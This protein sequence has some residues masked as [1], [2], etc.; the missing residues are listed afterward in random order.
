M[1]SYQYAVLNILGAIFSLYALLILGYW[2]FNFEINF[3]NKSQGFINVSGIILIVLAPVISVI[4]IK[5]GN[6]YRFG[7]IL[8]FAYLSLWLCVLIRFFT[9]LN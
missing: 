1:R 3:P 4:I 7:K 8:G 2:I 5:W 9:L 6:Q